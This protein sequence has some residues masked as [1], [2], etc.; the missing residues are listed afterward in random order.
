MT[1]A[2]RKEF[3]AALDDLAS[4][5]RHIADLDSEPVLVGVAQ[6]L[7]DAADAVEGL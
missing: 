3:I 7:V 6:K 4:R 2:E 1:P 5:A